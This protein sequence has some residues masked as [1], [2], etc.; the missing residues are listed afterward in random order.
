MIV[1]LAWQGEEQLEPNRTI[2]AHLIGPD[3]LLYAGDDQPAA[4]KPAGLTINRFR[5]TPLLQAPPA[6]YDLVVGS[7]GPLAN[8]AGHA[9]K[10]AQVRVLPASTPAY[11]AN[12]TY[13]P[14]VGSQDERT[15]IGFDWDGTLPGR[16]RLY[17]HYSSAGG[18]ETQTVDVDGG[19][20]VLPAWFGPWGIE[21]AGT[22]FARQ[23]PSAYVPL[24]QGL[25]WLG[26]SRDN[27]QSWT[28]G[29]R[30]RLGQEFAASRPV[31]SDQVISLRLVGYQADGQRWAWWDLDDSVPAMGAIP[32]LKWVSGS[33]VHHPVYSTISP[34]AQPGQPSEPLLLLYDAFTAHQ[35]PILDEQI[36][37]R[38][39]WIPIGR[40]PIAP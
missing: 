19:Q 31:L 3:G 25:V 30:V 33:R 1:Q 24:G 22:A 34:D 6:S 4:A 8:D 10:V 27:T 14:L 11:T 12:K 17:L 37:Q 40:V 15:L 26:Q 20:Y 18:F 7:Y 9:A 36:T 35:L 39:P 38:A 23:Q 21:I 29:T 13:R 28:P 5:L 32:T 16:Q 2:Y